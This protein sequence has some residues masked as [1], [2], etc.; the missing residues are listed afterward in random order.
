MDALELP[1]LK[2]APIFPV[3]IAGGYF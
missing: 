2:C 3:N 1:V